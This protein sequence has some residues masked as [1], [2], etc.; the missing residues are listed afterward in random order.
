MFLFFA[1]LFVAGKIEGFG[2]RRF[3]IAAVVIEARRGVKRKFARGGKVLA[4]DFDRVEVQLA[5]HH[6]HDALD[7]VGR[8]RTTSAAICVGGHLVR[9][10][11]RDIHLNR[12]NLVSATQH[13]ARQSRNRRRQQL[14]ISAEICDHVVAQSRQRAVVLHTD[15]DGADLGAT[16]DRGRNVFT[17]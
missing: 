7:N 12:G 5:R 6:V 14:M 16:V 10:D 4:T 17:P 13:Q 9:E 8:F 15:F 3:V 11:A 1:Q 2:E